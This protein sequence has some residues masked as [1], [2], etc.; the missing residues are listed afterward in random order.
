MWSAAGSWMVG[1]VL[2]PRHRG[3]P[4][5]ASNLRRALLLAVLLAVAVPALAS[6]ATVTRLADGTLVY[7]AAAGAVKNH[8]DV[9]VADDDSTITFYT[10]SGDPMNAP[11]GCSPSDLY[12]GDVVTCTM[13]K[14]IR[15]ELG[16][17]DDDANLSDGIPVPVTVNGGAGADWLDAANQPAVLDGGAGDDKLVGGEGDDVLRGGDGNDTIE[18]KDGRDR[19]DGGAGDDLLSP[20]GYEHANA[21][22]VD[23]GPGTDRIESDY[24]SRFSDTDA[25]V[26]ITFGGGADDGRPG[27]GDDLR[28]VEKVW[29]N[30]GGSF[31]GTDGPDEFRLSQVGTPST[32]AGGGGDDNLRSGDGADHLDGGAGNDIVDG[33][34]GDDVLIG[35]PGRDA[36]S[37]DLAGGDC[38]PLWC[39]YPYGND[40]IEARDG[41]VDS[42]TCGAGTDTVI[43]DP[44]DIVARD[45]ENVDRGSAP[46]AGAGSAPTKRSAVKVTL[47]GRPRLAK[48]LRS[49]FSV[50]VSGAQAGQRVRLTATRGRKVVARGSAKVR[51]GAT[52]VT[53]RLRFTPAARETLRHKRRATLVVR[54]LTINLR[55]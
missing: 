41:E 2:I 13:P 17:G 22:V 49:G 16:A 51:A 30:V 36:I 45:C 21:D 9:Q 10:S 12:G 11:A 5:T 24:S 27:E 31:T 32:M 14:A 20:D 19:I 48:A 54:G 47:R 18:G 8:V 40:T 35:G 28:N 53:V 38:G 55:R 1:I 46:N 39:K 29:L 44:Q 37:G 15:V 7:T 43:A 33:G 23:G 6:A 25:P 34:F 52:T 42:I 26:A 50:R 3:V 4:M